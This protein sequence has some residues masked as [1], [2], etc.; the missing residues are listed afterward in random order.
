L[1]LNF[2]HELNPQVL[3]NDVR[4]LRITI[5]DNIFQSL[6]ALLIA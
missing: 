5:V 4:G 3:S 6:R 2:T 1:F